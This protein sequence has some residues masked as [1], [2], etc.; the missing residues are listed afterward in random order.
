MALIWRTAITEG[1]AENNPTDHFTLFKL[2]AKSPKVK[3][4]PDIN[5]PENGDFTIGLYC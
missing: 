5:T 2:F 3:F 1:S 4:S